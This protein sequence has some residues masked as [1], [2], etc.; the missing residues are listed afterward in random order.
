MSLESKI[1]DYCIS[2][3]ANDD[4]IISVFKEIQGLNILSFTAEFDS[5]EACRN[6]LKQSETRFML[7]VSAVHIQ[8]IFG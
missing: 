7:S 3:N 6:L 1:L 8:N 5:E 4:Y 2:A